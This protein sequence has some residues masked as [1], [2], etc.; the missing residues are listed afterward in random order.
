MYFYRL[1]DV[2]REDYPATAAILGEVDFHNLITGYLV[3]YPPTEPSIAHCGQHL[4]KYLRA[5]PQSGKKPW[6]A[7]LATLERAMLDV[8]LA[9]D[10]KPLDDATMK[11]IPPAQWP[12]LRM[13]TIPA[14]T[15]LELNWNVSKLA[16]A[17]ESG[18]KSRK[19]AKGACAIIAWRRNDHVFHRKLDNPERAPL[20]ALAQGARFDRVCRIIADEVGEPGAAETIAKMLQ[21]WLGEG[22][23]MLVQSSAWRSRTA[24]GR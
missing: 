10:A 1:L 8:L 4:A 12:T 9:P 5:R 21:R 17:I 14:I 20:K 7:D 11:S 13:R 18:H 23:L 19:P 2:L 22:V 6:L 24:S 15:I 16:D 3:E